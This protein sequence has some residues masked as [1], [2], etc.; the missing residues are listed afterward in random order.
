MSEAK[1]GAVEAIIHKVGEVLD[2][3]SESELNQTF[4]LLEDL[5]AILLIEEL[6]ERTLALRSF[7]TVHFV[8]NADK[9]IKLPALLDRVLDVDGRI[10]EAISDQAAIYLAKWADRLHKG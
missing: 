7:F 3:L 6:E 9:W 5:V 4:D 8:A 2:F 1:Q 10:L